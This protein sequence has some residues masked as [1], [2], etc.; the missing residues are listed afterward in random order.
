[1]VE[2]SVIIPSYAPGGYLKECLESVIN[3]TLPK[4]NFEI[5][6]VLN[7]LRDP[8]FSQIANFISSYDN[9]RLL[10]EEKAGVSNARNKGIEDARGNYICFIDD[11][12]VVSPTYLSG[13]LE[14]SDRETIGISNVYSFRQNIQER[15]ANFFICRLL[16]HKQKY[17]GTSFFRCR[18]F[19]AFP[20]AKLIHREIIAK[21]RFDCRFRNGED[22]L[23][24]TSITDN[25]AQIRFSSDDAIYYVRERSG[26]ASRKKIGLLKII[27]S[28]FLLITEYIII[29]MRH[30]F[31]YS[32]M[33][34]I[35]RI[36]GVLKNAFL[37][38]KN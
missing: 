27:S 30:P 1:M 18:S 12:D 36:P 37:L 3:Q 8:Y 23:F 21:H 5:I 25:F 34:F 11:D 28:S 16:L 22:A 33:L 29:Y 26:S 15:N 38:S 14:V 6:I 17:E 24:I 10:Y 20:V 4:N 19:L 35:A 7:G 31:R 2:I 9:I 13:L 32:F